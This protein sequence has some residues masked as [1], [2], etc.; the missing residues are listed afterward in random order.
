MNK[1]G[2][3]VPGQ[4]LNPQSASPALDPCPNRGGQSLGLVYRIVREFYLRNSKE[5][6]LAV[7]SVSRSSANTSP[8]IR[9]RIPSI[10][11]SSDCCTAIGMQRTAP[12]TPVLEG[13]VW[14]CQLE[15]SFEVV[16]VNKASSGA[17]LQE[18][19][20]GVCQIAPENHKQRAAHKLRSF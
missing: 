3:M 13:L 15:K 17:Q 20:N 10:R 12:S 16:M 14:R 6:V 1:R 7:C 9:P 18:A 11:E 5:Q 2:H 4:V 19:K 8:I